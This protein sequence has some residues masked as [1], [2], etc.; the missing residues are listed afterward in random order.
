MRLHPKLSL[1]S[2]WPEC[3]PSFPTNSGSGKTCAWQTT[4]LSLRSYSQKLSENYALTAAGQTQENKTR[5]LA[6]KSK[7]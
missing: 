5:C 3:Y 2:A 1:T 4:Q 7:R 6:Q